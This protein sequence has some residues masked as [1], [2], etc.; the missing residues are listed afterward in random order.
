MPA[1][2]VKRLVVQI[3]VRVP[4]HAEHHALQHVVHLKHRARVA[5]QQL[6][7]QH[8]PPLPLGQR[9]HARQRSRHRDQPQQLVLLVPQQHA[10][11]QHL[12]AQVRK[13]MMAVHDLRR[14]HG[15]YVQLEV[16]LQILLL[17]RRQCLHRG[18]AQPLLLQPALHLGKNLIALFVKRSRR[19][20]DGAQLLVRGHAALAVHALL[21]HRRDVA[22]TA[23]ADHIEFVQIAGKDRYKLHPL[24]QRHGLVLGLR[25]HARIELEPGKLPVLGESLLPERFCH[26]A[27]L[28][29][30]RLNFLH[31]I[32]L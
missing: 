14:E 30:V 21:V 27:Q 29:S 26:D 28:L 4:R 20:V 7:D 2:R 11:V 9:H 5:E 8:I 15:L 19:R 13:R 31:Y 16:L 23:H 1:L 6:L 17:H 22:Q 3:D 10:D 12:A 32:R 25:Q 18:V 24:Q